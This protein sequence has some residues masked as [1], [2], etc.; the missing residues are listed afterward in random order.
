MRQIVDEP[1]RYN[2]LLDVVMT[3]VPSATCTVKGKIQD[4]NYLVVNLNLSVQETIE[5]DRMVWNYSKAD[6]ERLNDELEA[7]DWDY[8]WSLNSTEAANRLTEIILHYSEM[9]IGKR[10]LTEIKSSHPW[11]NDDIIE[12]MKAKRKAE[13]TPMEADA[14]KHCSEVI[15]SARWDYVRKTKKD[16]KNMKRGSKQWYSKSATLMGADSKMWARF[17]R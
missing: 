12:C 13:G 10:K 2:N 11:M 1:T 7:Y 3:D 5:V 17:R 16:L 8:L 14:T 15:L 4:H 9:C 6:W